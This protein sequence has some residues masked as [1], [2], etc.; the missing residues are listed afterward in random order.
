MRHFGIIGNPLG[1]SFSRE[2]FNSKFEKEG[3]NAKYDNYLLT[4]ISHLQVILDKNPL[5]EGINVTLPFKKEIIKLLS[6]IES[7]AKEIG[8]VNVVKIIRGEN[9]LSLHGFNTDYIGFKESLVNVLNKDIK[10][11]L[12]LGTGGSSLAVQKGLTDLGIG[13]L[14]VSRTPVEGQL[15]YNDLDEDIMSRNKLIINTTP[16]GMFPGIEDAPD[17]PYNFLGKENIL[18]DLVYNPKETAFLKHGKRAGCKTR[19][20]IEMLHIQAEEAWKIWN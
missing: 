13:Y 20:G 1:H 5:L 15:N 16:L 4:N 10:T 9:G 2:Y 17:I 18:F 14:M 11:A 6:N 8:A 3:L 12:I 7:A 19:G